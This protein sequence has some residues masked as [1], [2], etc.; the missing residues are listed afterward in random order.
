[1]PDIRGMKNKV[2]DLIYVMKVSGIENT[3]NFK[4]AKILCVPFLPL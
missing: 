1:M 3:M 2:F 4:G